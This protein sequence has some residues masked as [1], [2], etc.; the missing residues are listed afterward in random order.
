MQI[1]FHGHA[2]IQITGQEH[3]ILV[4]PFLTGN[5]VAVE[6]AETIQA[7]TILLTHG[8]DDHTGDAINIAKRNDATV[9]TIVELAAYLSLQGLESVVPMNIGGGASFPFGEL[10]WVPAL[11]SSSAIV[12]GEIIY[13]GN[14]AGFVLQMEGV[15]IYHAGD[16][17]LFSDMKLIGERYAPDIAFLPIGSHFTM[18]P[19][20]ALLAAQWLQAKVVVPIH[21]N[22]F[23]LIEQDGHE[24][25]EKLK[26]FGI[27][28][29]VME[30]GQVL[31][32]STWQFV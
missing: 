6:S 24:Y 31:D 18:D 25:A 2:C 13:L 10:K 27:K 32:T 5:P 4:D 14:P 8:H 7:D 1:K 17:A 15:T 20:D 28:G 16:T 30:P 23:S 9:I 29:I 12:D 3:S 11:H 21:Y 19:T 22:T 26:Q